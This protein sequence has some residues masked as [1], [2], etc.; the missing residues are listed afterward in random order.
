MRLAHGRGRTVDTV[1]LWQSDR[2]VKVGVLVS[3]P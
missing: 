2:N 3:I 1:E